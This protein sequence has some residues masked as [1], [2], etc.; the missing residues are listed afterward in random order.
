[1]TYEFIRP[2]QKKTF[3]ANLQ[4][5]CNDLLYNFLHEQLKPNN[6]EFR[7]SR[8]VRLTV[9]PQNKVKN[10]NNNKLGHLI[11]QMSCCNTD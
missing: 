6:L 11:C 4:E 10:V 7:N 5:R 2:N 9:I 1:M 3:Y 8:S